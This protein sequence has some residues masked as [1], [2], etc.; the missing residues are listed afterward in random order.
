M[1]VECKDIDIK[2]KEKGGNGVRGEFFLNAYDVYISSSL[3]CTDP[4]LI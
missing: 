1:A 2:D 4:Y 3:S